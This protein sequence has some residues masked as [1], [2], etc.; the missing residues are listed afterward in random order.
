MMSDLR[1]SGSIEQDADVV[2]FVYRHEEYLKREEPIKKSTESDEKFNDRYQR[3]E[4]LKNEFAGIGEVIIAKNRHGPIGN[5]R[6]YY[7]SQRTM[8]LN[9][10]GD[11]G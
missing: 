1:E 10:A 5:V 7:D 11:H 6:C 4:T 2:M 3:W 9:L 8:F